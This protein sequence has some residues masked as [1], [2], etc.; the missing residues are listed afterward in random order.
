MTLELEKVK[1]YASLMKES[2]S[3]NG[4]N[5]P[6]GWA[7][8]TT[9]DELGFSQ[10]GYYGMLCKNEATGEL[11]LIHRGTEVGNGFLGIITNTDFRDIGSDIELGLSNSISNQIEMAKGFAEAIKNMEGID[12]S[13]VKN[14]GHSL[15]GYLSDI[16]EVTV[17]GGAGSFTINAPGVK[18]ILPKLEEYF[19]VEE[20]TYA[21]QDFDN[22]I[23][24]DAA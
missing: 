2:Y 18:N 1:E 13:K 8:V 5:L 19:G 3:N 17:S 24:F 14:L 22:I 10:N 7:L 12:Y 20:G 11:G 16:V 23:N 15:G 4:G 6:E 9:S 21:N